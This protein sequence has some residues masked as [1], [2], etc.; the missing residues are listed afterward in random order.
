MIHDSSER[1]ST[2]RSSTP[3]S[4]NIQ[5][6][7]GYPS[8]TDRL[9]MMKMT[10]QEKNREITELK[11]ALQKL[12]EENNELKAR[13]N[14]KAYETKQKLKHFN[15][16]MGGGPQQLVE[17]YRNLYKAYEELVKTN[18]QTEES[19][20]L[21][22]IRGE[23]QRA[24][25]Q[26]LKQTIENQINASGLL[27]YLKKTHGGYGSK[28]KYDSRDD[29][30]DS[31]I[32]IA[33]M[34]AQI[35]KLKQVEGDL[36][37]EVQRLET[38]LQDVTHERDKLKVS[39]EKYHEMNEKLNAEV[40]EMLN[41]L[42]V[43]QDENAK[44][45]EEK[46]SLLDYID[47]T[48]NN[49]VPRQDYERLTHKNQD[50]LERVKEIERD[51][52]SLKVLSDEIDKQR[53][54]AHDQLVERDRNIEQLKRERDNILSTLREREVNA[55]DKA[56]ELKNYKDQVEEKNRQIRDLQ[57]K[58]DTLNDNYATLNST[59]TELQNDLDKSQE[60]IKDLQNELRISQEKAAI[61][62]SSYERDLKEAQLKIKDLEREISNLL[63]RIQEGE[64]LRSTLIHE[65]ITLEKERTSKSDE[66]KNLYDQISNLRSEIRSH[67]DENS[68]LK[69]ENSMLIEQL[70]N[71]KAEMEERMQNLIMC[72]Q[73]VHD[74][75]KKCEEKDKT[76]KKLKE[77]NNL[78]EKENTL[79]KRNETFRPKDKSYESLKEE[80]KQLQEKVD[81]LN[82][83]LNRLKELEAS[84]NKKESANVVE[85]FNNIIRELNA[86][87]DMSLTEEERKPAANDLPLD[88]LGKETHE[89]KYREILRLID[90]LKKEIDELGSKYTQ[91][92]LDLLKEM[93]KNRELEENQGESPSKLKESYRALTKEL[94]ELQQE[95]NNLLQAKENLHRK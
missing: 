38:K 91:A 49:F 10:I 28:Q 5:P 30:L 40:Q 62:S 36:K 70:D 67:K 19:L 50:L 85:Y 66:L 45:N 52:E 79:L 47:N 3:N 1:Y 21:E 78:L 35:Q 88:I 61:Q 23:E 75:V 64:S 46:D 60:R 9:S 87:L 42:N 43:A 56:Q 81:M 37:A 74:L 2:R 24:Y 39:N 80:N 7:N 57:N 20:R 89:K 12:K 55:N 54:L 16:E 92:K 32:D 69:S 51:Y 77:Q 25:I 13:D 71:L 26:V 48:K 73:E 33:S 59:I 29:Y 72:N 8:L 76:I 53:K 44:L 14:E 84:E 27:P 63:T 83:K 93:E 11:A 90:I 17:Q 4:Q 15:I 41:A 22:T 18:M 68:H 86:T 65:K 34:N 82:A 6:N 94:S 58:L 31:Y 95:R